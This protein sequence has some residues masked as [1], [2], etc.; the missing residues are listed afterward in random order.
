M[1][2]LKTLPVIWRVGILGGLI[3]FTLVSLAATLWYSDRATS[4]A[5][6]RQQNF[7]QIER[8]ALEVEIGALQMRRRE[9]DFLLRQETRYFDAYQADAQQVSAYLDEISALDAPADIDAAIQHLIDELPLHEQTF[10]RVVEEQTRLGLS[11]DAGLQGELRSAV[12]NVEERLEAF[13]DAELTVLMLMM[14]RHEKDFMLR[15]SPRYLDSFDQR[16]AEF[17]DLLAQ[18]DYPAADQA[19]ITALMSDYARDFHAWAEG[20]LGKQEIVSE[21]SAIFARMEPDFDT[22]MNR[23]RE[24]GRAANAAL[25]TE[26]EQIRVLTMGIVGAIAVIAGLLCWL[27]SR[28]IAQPINALTR[29][30]GVLAGGD[31]GQTIPATDQGGEIGQMAASVVFFQQSLIEV[32]RLRAEQA[33]KEARAAEEKRRMMAEMADEFDASVGSIA[34]DVATAAMNMI[35]VADQLRSTAQRSDE[36]SAIV[37]SAAEETSANTQAVASAAEELTSSIRE[38]TRQVNES[39]SLTGDAVQEA[40]VT[41]ETMSGLSEAVTKIGTVVTLI[42]SIAEQTNLLA[43]NATIEA[44]RA[45]DAGKGFAVVASEV[46]ALADQTARATHDIADQIDAIQQSGDRAVTA[47]SS[48]TGMIDKVS[49]STTAIASAIEQQDAAAQEIANS[50]S[51]AAAGTSQVTESI[52]ALSGNVRETD[53]GAGS[54]LQAAR[55]VSGDADRLKSALASFLD[56]IRA[57]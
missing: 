34:E 2:G 20:E 55:G 47:I 50:V 43:L 24:E 4:A 14:R 39:Q 52:A 22:I 51:Q 56:Q 29:S 37:A 35:A 44:S 1:R 19:E 17:A 40:G 41:R 16:Q 6:E 23:A 8:L 57:A 26:R 36:R 53:E 25:D 48:M 3:G 5:L 21:L 33:D 54:V 9:K 28:S 12:H 18:R 30:M 38:I 45:G 13:Q 42:Q 46:K 31:T 49:E 15:G 10:A 7:V 11:H 32:E 27:V